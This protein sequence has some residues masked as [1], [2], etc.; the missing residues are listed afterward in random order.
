MQR[1]ITSSLALLALVALGC[2]GGGSG[3]TSSTVAVRSTDAGK[4]LVDSSGRTLY[5]FG[6][7]HGDKSS[8]SGAC[9]QAW[10]PLTTRGH[11]TAGGGVAMSLLGTTSR[12]D[13]TSEVT[14]N[15]HPLYTFTGDSKP[16]D[17][18]GQGS[19][20]FGA[21]WYVLGA[22]GRAVTSSP[23]PASPTRGYGY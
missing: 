12:A 17:V 18:N 22:P 5:L 7:D 10:P 19:T 2:G 20:A 6:K 16:G 8:C 14:Y 4:I 11:L 9:A 21:R 15:G 13:G 23:A 1:R 3:G